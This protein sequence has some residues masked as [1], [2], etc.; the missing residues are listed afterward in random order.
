[1]DTGDDLG[2]GDRQQVVVALHV[3]GPVGEPFTA[4]TRL[5]RPI[6]LD[7]GAH[8]PVEHE[9]AFAQYRGE[10]FGGIGAEQRCVG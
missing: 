8:R 10:R 3:T 4:I 2:L 6:A 5:V 7:R 9:D 1:M